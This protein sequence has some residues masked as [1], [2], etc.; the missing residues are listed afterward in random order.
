[1]KFVD[2][3]GEEIEVV[4]NLSCYANNGSLFMELLDK[5]T[6]EPYS[7]LTVNLWNE[8]PENMAFIDTNNCPEAEIFI[9][10]NELG[11]FTGYRE[12]SGFCK[13]P[14]YE[15]D[16]NKLREEREVL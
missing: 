1:M 6:Y 5:E 7:S 10:E 4:I 3:F 15:F 14:L 8:L 11:S 16:L 13:Y 9:K 2:S 12:Q